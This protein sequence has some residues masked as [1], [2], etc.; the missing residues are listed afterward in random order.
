MGVTIIDDPLPA[1]IPPHED[2]YHCQF[3]PE[4]KLPP[5]SPRVELFPGQIGEVPDMDVGATE[6]VFKITVVLKQV[7]ELQVPTAFT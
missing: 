2:V 5:I 6:F 1:E 7:V 3:A 4:P